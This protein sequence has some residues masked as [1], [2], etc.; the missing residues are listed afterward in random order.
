M[1]WRAQ[2]GGGAFRHTP[3]MALYA[4]RRGSRSLRHLCDVVHGQLHGGCIADAYGD[5]AHIENHGFELEDDE[6]LVGI[7]ALASRR[8]RTEPGPDY[9]AIIDDQRFVRA[10]NYRGQ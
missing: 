9:E 3:V 5:A 1:T 2:F 6:Q 4:R 10:Q 8:D 7:V